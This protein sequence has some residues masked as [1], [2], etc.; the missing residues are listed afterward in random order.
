MCTQLFIATSLNVSKADLELEVINNFYFKRYFQKYELMVWLNLR[1][2]EFG[3]A[4]FYQ[5]FLKVGHSLGGPIVVEVT[6]RKT[7]KNI[8]GVCVLD[9]VEEIALDSLQNMDAILKRRPSSFKSLNDAINY[10]SIK[11]IKVYNQK[12]F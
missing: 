10:K 11:F 12:T 1:C 2:I 3:V 6:C 8:I 9:V 7:I 5:E 4:K